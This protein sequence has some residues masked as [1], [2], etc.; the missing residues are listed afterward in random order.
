MHDPTLDGKA[1]GT[2]LKDGKPIDESLLDTYVT[3]LVA[4]LKKHFKIQEDRAVQAAGYVMKMMD[5]F[6][7]VK[8][9]VMFIDM[10]YKKPMVQMTS[11]EKQLMLAVGY[12]VRK[13]QPFEAKA[14]KIGRNDPCVCGSGKK[15][16]QCCLE[17]AKAQD[18]KRYTD[19]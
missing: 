19:G 14:S 11:D 1:P 6:P 10:K 5:D 2:V 12:F 7:S 13:R 4:G 15:Y 18:L 3:E 9:A 17:I 16:K 8:D